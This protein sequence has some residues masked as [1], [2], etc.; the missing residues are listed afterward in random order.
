MM[1]RPEFH[2]PDRE[3]LKASM[4]PN[5]RSTATPL[6]SSWQ[7]VDS[8]LVSLEPPSGLGRPIATRRECCS[9]VWVWLVEDGSC[10]KSV[11]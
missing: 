7:R 8:S 11:K 9:T 4:D 3:V 6:G 1:I 5:L 2:R 10:T